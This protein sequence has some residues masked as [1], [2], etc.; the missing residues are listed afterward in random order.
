MCLVSLFLGTRGAL[1]CLPTYHHAK[2]DLLSA[3]LL[4]DGLVQDDVQED[5]VAAQNA[6]NLATAIQLDEE[7][8]VEVLQHVGVSMGAPSRGARGLRWE[9]RASEGS[10]G[11]SGCGSRPTS[12]LASLSRGRGQRTFL[13]SG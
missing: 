8:L 2:L 9:G 12:T 4:L 6:D 10:K 7:P 3:V 1:D 5:V 13:S 11:S